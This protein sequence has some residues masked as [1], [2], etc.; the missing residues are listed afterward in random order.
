M[1]KLLLISVFVVSITVTFGQQSTKA[2]GKI[3]R[4]SVVKIDITPEDSQMLAGYAARKSTGVNDRIF[5]RIVALDDGKAQFF[6][7]STEIGKMSPS[8]YD[9]VAAQLKKKLGAW[10]YASGVRI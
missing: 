9:R 4:A 2:Q 3:F 6:L 10:L 8:Q 5:H 7:V 1:N